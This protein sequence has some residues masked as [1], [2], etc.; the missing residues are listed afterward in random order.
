[1]AIANAV[2]QFFN[3]RQDGD[4]VLTSA[5]PVLRAASVSSQKIYMNISTIYQNILDN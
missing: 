1:L 3:T 2:W 5:A 4:F